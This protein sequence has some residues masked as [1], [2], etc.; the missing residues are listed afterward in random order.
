MSLTLLGK[1]STPLLV[2]VEPRALRHE[3]RLFNLPQLP[4]F[5]GAGM[6]SGF[7]FSAFGLG[8]RRAGGASGPVGGGGATTG[9]ALGGATTTGGCG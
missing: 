9:G 1:H 6:V 7:S 8:S 5:G 2:G 3:E 4:A